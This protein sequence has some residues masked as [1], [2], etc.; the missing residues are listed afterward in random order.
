LAVFFLADDDDVGDEDE[1]EDEDDD[2]DDKEDKDATRAK[3]TTTW[4]AKV[5]NAAFAKQ[6]RER[7]WMTTLTSKRATTDK[8]RT[9]PL[10]RRRPQKRPRT[11]E[12]EG[13]GDSAFRNSSL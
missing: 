10:R 11:V 12:L 13:A 4:T 7:R 6:V 2:G 1:D 5:R 9:R 3:G 8:R